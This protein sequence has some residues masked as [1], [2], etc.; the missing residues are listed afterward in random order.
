MRCQYFIHLFLA[1]IKYSVYAKQML[2]N[3]ETEILTDFSE[4]DGSR[5]FNLKEGT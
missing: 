1:I 3:A 4:R 5:N 2:L